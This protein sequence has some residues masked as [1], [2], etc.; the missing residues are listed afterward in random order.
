[1]GH[2][3]KLKKVQ[4]SLARNASARYSYLTE[5]DRQ[6]SAIYLDENG[7]GSYDFLVGNPDFNYQEL[8]S[9]FVIRWEYRPGSTIYLVWTHNRFHDS[10]IYDSSAWNSLKG[11]SGISSDNALMVKLSYWFSL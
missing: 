5:V 4:E 10:D 2:F 3:S 7:D 6:G 8:R 11:I 1:M 9:N